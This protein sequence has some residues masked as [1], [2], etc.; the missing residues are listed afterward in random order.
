MPWHKVQADPS[1]ANIQ[2]EFLASF[3]SFGGPKGM[4][5]FSSGGNI[6]YFSPRCSDYIKAFMEKIGCEPC[7]KPAKGSVVFLDGDDS[8]RDTLL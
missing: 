2:K 4:A 7:D 5:L 1:T 8:D 6:V 3:M